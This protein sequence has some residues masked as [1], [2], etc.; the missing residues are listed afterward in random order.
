MRA[1]PMIWWNVWASHTHMSGTESPN[2]YPICVCATVYHHRPLPS[3][4]LFVQTCFSRTPTPVLALCLCSTPPSIPT[5]KDTSSASC[6]L[7]T[8]WGC[9]LSLMRQQNSSESIS[10]PCLRSICESVGS[11]VRK[12]L[13]G[14]LVTCQAC[15]RCC[16]T[17][18]PGKGVVV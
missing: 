14:Y 16:C 9:G 15:Q 17:E 1:N 7:W 11:S 4:L 13:C 10:V 6:V 2:S 5:V 12:R 18:G 8:C 3:S